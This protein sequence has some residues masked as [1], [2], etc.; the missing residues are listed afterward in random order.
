[1]H[2]RWSLSLICVGHSLLA[3]FSYPVASYLYPR[4]TPSRYC[5]ANTQSQFW[6]LGHQG[7]LLQSVAFETFSMSRLPDVCSRTSKGLHLT[8]F[9]MDYSHGRR[10]RPANDLWQLM[11]RSLYRTGCWELVPG[12]ALRREQ[13]R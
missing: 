3:V 2:V 1:M 5:N 11:K 10:Q 12:M 8:T 4:G 7:W 9:P 6:P 13:R